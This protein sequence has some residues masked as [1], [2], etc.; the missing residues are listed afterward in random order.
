MGHPPNRWVGGLSYPTGIFR[1]MKYQ[2][3]ELARGVVL[4]WD[5]VFWDHEV[6]A[7]TIRVKKQGID[8]NLADLFTKLCRLLEEQS[9]CVGLP[10]ETYQAND[11]Y[12]CNGFRPLSRFPPCQT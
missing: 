2:N 10:I 6:A 5:L 12:K 9:C 8:L 1:S 7:G 3:Q 11:R 4:F